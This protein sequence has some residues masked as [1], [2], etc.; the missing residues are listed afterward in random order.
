[1]RDFTGLLIK[2]A[3]TRTHIVAK[4]ET[5]GRIARM[6][7]TTVQRLAADNNLQDPDRINIGQ[8]LVVPAPATPRPAMVRDA[9]LPKSQYV[10]DKRGNR[11]VV[12]YPQTTYSLPQNLESSFVDN[13][14]GQL[15]Q[16]AG[17]NATPEQLQALVD[18]A[19]NQGSGD[20]AL[21]GESL[22]SDHWE[23]RPKGGG[24][25]RPDRL[26]DK[27]YAATVQ[28]LRNIVENMSNTGSKTTTDHTMFRHT[29]EGK[30]SALPK[31]F[32][33]YPS[34]LTA[35]NQFDSVK[36]PHLVTY[37]NDTYRHS[38]QAAEQGGSK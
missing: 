9:H 13:L 4:G 38:H 37:R 33:G 20:P 5:L 25:G 22:S 26:K 10:T 15:A 32:V 11:T 6:Y 24:W 29:S 23:S 19:V 21:I 8:Q 31:D 36:G 27:G 34:A 18:V 14:V 1:M 16:E 3:Q 7:G 35:T 12:T 28:A 17:P 30:D 2:Y